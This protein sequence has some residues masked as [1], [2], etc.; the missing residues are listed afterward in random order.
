MS[1]FE[2]VPEFE[3]HDHA[4]RSSDHRG[5][6]LRRSAR[7][8]ACARAQSEGRHREDFRASARRPV[9]R[10]HGLGAQHASGTG[11]G[12][13]RDGG[14]ADL[15]QIASRASA[16]RNRPGRRAR[17][18]WRQ[19]CAGGCSGFSDA[20]FRRPADGARSLGPRC[21]RSRRARAGARRPHAQIFGHALRSLDGLFAAAHP[22]ARSSR[23]ADG[24]RADLPH[25]GSAGAHR[26]CARSDAALDPADALPAAGLG[27]RRSP[28]H[29][30]RE[31][32]F[33][34]RSSLRA[35]A[36]WRSVRW[37][38]SARFF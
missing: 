4:R 19:L 26:A 5:R 13:S 27:D 14:V 35:T 33:W 20:R 38:R 22:R 30:A 1:E 7:S 2:T 11:G 36:G 23:L 25:R 9:S 12:L 31:H 18:R 10:L 17:T 28:S 37:R 3:V 29:R 21:V 16:G 34:P 24:A 6:R 15:F 32:V 8:P